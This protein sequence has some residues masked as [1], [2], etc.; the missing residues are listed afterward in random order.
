MTNDRNTLEKIFGKQR[1]GLSK[2]GVCYDPSMLF[3]SRAKFMRVSH[4]NLEIDTIPK[5]L[6]I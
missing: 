2:D 5:T 3:N 1:V 6:T 4:P